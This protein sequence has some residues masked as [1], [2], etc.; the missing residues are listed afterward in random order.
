MFD[1][2]I[3]PNYEDLYHEGRDLLREARE[4]IQKQRGRADFFE[5]EYLEAANEIKRMATVL[6]EKLTEE[7]RV[8]ILEEIDKIK[9]N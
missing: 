5:K 4:E 1:D 8:E 6:K 3:M 7:Q 9:I 2:L